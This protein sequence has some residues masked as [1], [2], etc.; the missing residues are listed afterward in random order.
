MLSAIADQMSRALGLSTANCPGKSTGCG[1]TGA[2]LSLEVKNLP[3]RIRSGMCD[4]KPKGDPGSDAVLDDGLDTDGGLSRVADGA[5]AEIGD[6]GG[7]LDFAVDA[8]DGPAVAT[9]NIPAT[10]P[11]AEVGIVDVAAV[12]GC[13]AGESEGDGV[14]ALAL[15]SAETSSLDRAAAAVEVADDTVLALVPP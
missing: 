1:S 7:G 9:P 4:P 11:T 12:G 2:F 15:S 5:D 14:T 10:P 13:F 3:T 8:T 6:T